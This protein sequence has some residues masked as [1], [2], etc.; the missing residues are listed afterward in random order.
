MVKMALSATRA[1]EVIDY[2]SVHPG[3]AFS[4]TELCRALDINPASTLAVLASLTGSGY[5]NRHPVH[6]TYTLGAALVAVGHAALVRHPVLE[7]AGHELAAVSAE[8]QAQCVG[9][10]LMGDL[11]VAV[12]SEGRPRRAGIWSRIGTRAPF[13]APVGAPFAA[14][15]DESLEARWLRRRTGTVTS[16]ER[17][18]RLREALAVVRSRGF[19]AGH[20]SEQ[21]ELGR[22]LWALGDDPGNAAL[23]SEVDR[24]F[25][26]LSDKF[27]LANT[28]G[29]RVEGIS[30]VTVPVFS[31]AAE[32]VLIITAV[33]FGDPLGK[34]DLDQVGDRLRSSAEAITVGTFG[35]TAAG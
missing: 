25:D 13:S 28:E 34:D 8:I 10:V 30:S 29:G 33:G 17:V 19:A 4:L 1:L 23:R 31:P 12:I 3:Q 5:V 6:K 24:V 9:T 32:V 21:E 7:T 26:D 20:Q 11:L 2:L 22:T 15:G 18:A 27:V 14:Y 16:S 35:K